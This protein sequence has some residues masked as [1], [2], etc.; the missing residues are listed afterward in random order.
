MGL[1][2]M[3]VEMM[4]AREDTA[5]GAA[6]FLHQSHWHLFSPKYPCLENKKILYIQLSLRK[7]H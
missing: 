3:D 2:W 7:D 6:E 1:D 4:E 5:V